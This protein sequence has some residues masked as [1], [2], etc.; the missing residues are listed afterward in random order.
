MLAGDLGRPVGSHAYERRV[1]FMDSR[2]GTSH[3]GE[4]RA[5]AGRTSVEC[6]APCLHVFIRPYPWQ[7]P[8]LQDISM[9][10]NRGALV[11]VVGPVGSGKTSLVNAFMGS[12]PRVRASLWTQFF[13]DGHTL[14][15]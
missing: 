11:M 15:P 10:V 3:I 12:I 7:A 4:G 9:E 5:R 8:T 2:S 13:H 1:I 6:K 14:Q